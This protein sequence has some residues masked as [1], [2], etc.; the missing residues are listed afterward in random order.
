MALVH[1]D[2][3]ERI[4]GTA[5]DGA[6]QVSVALLCVTL[7][8]AMF[9]VFGGTLVGV[10]LVNLIVLLVGAGAIVWAWYGT[11]QRWWRSGRRLASVSGM[12]TAVA[13]TLVAVTV[14]LTVAFRLAD[15]DGRI[16]DSFLWRLSEGDFR[17]TAER[18]AAGGP[19]VHNGGRFVGLLWVER[20]EVRPRRVRFVLPGVFDP[21]LIIWERAGR[22][23]YE[24]TDPGYLADGWYIRPGSLDQD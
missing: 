12:V 20:I 19:M 23:S 15:P 17:S 1:G 24:P 3:G 2:T 9:A 8:W 6:V 11:L 10:F 14:V 4:G 13:L 5:R 16:R 22:P 21:G 7:A 18:L